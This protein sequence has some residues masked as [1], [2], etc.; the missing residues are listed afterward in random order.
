MVEANHKL[1]LT[2]ALVVAVL[3]LVLVVLEQQDKETM[4]ELAQKHLII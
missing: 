3:G 1:A 2:V 4:V